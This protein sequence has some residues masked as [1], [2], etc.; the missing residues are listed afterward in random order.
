MPA[1]VAPTPKPEVAPAK[2]VI[3]T[4]TAGGLAAAGAGG[5]LQQAGD[6]IKTAAGTHEWLMWIGTALLV[7]G[8][9]FAL[10]GRWDAMQKGSAQ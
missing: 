3:K 6:A 2:S 1:A 10:Y 8:L 9:L 7:A 4:K 5:S